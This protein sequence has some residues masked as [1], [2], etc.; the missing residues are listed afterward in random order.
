MADATE[1]FSDLGSSKQA[2]IQ[3]TVIYASQPLQRAKSVSEAVL[4][5]ALSK[6]DC[7]YGFTGCFTSFSIEFSTLTRCLMICF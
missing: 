7:L 1:V 5:A 2:V 3:F 4:L 6:D